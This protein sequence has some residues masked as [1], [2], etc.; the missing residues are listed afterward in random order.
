MRRAVIALCALVVATLLFVGWRMNIKE[1]QVYSIDAG[2]HG[3]VDR[4]V[5]TYISWGTPRMYDDNT[6]M[7]YDVGHPGLQ[8]LAMIGV[9]EIQDKHHMGTKEDCWEL[10]PKE[11]VMQ[12]NVKPY[13][14]D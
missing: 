14:A 8:G 9:D 4:Y 1:N 12:I 13:Y 11:S 10:A 3:N 2:Q 6:I 7:F 5:N